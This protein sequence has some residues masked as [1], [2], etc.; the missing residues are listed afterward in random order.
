MPKQHVSE[1][2]QSRKDTDTVP[3]M[4]NASKLSAASA[5]QDHILGAV[6]RTFALTIPQLPSGLSHVI[7]NAYLL[8]RIADTIED[9]ATL[10]SERKAYFQR[11][12]SDLILGQRDVGEFVQ[13]I[14]PLLGDCTSAAE[15][16]LVANTDKVLTLTHS[17]TRGQQQALYHCISVMSRGMSRFQH[18]IDL[19]GLPALSDLDEYCYFVA[20][21]VGEMLT[22]LFCQHDQ[23]MDGKR[24]KLMQLAPSFGQALQMTNILKDVWDDRQRGVCWWPRELF[25]EH[26]IDLQ[27][28]ES[29]RKS[30]GFT[31]ALEKLVGIAHGHI[32]N[33]LQYTLLIPRSQAGIR[34]F[35]L[36]SLALAVLTLQNIHR[37]PM[38]QNSQDIKV[39]RKRV[40]QIIALSRLFARSNLA[41][42]GLFQSARKGLPLQP[43]AGV[44]LPSDNYQS[45]RAPVTMPES[46]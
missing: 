16:E 35:C 9:E 28:L 40:A 24:G 15:R 31:P 3:V 33:A 30:S 19:S 46:S 37:N 10:D 1:P 5:F 13:Q 11:F 39:K 14:L 38:Y 23:Q 22:D 6:S 29:Q 32:L 25:A 8:C 41:I 45:S 27:Q 42:R 44:K 4:T 20:G 21:V 18:N 7:A 17:F 34:N 36:W 43:V 2:L 12:F 26:G